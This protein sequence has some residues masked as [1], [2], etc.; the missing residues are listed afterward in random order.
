[1]SG[2]PDTTRIIYEALT[3]QGGPLTALIGSRAWCPIAPSDW[4]NT[5]PAAI[6]T[7]LSPVL[8][9]STRSE[10]GE[11]SIRCYGGSSRFGDANDLMLL[12]GQQLH[13]KPFDLPSGGLAYIWQASNNPNLRDPE[14]GWPYAQAT[15]VYKAIA[16]Q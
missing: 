16:K 14:T 12:L 5:E 10:T 6:Y 15:W 2:P 9:V 13:D 4:Q 8:D 1:M 7:F 11:V 3:Y